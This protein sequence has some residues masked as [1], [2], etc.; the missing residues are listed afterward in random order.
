MLGAIKGG[1]MLP[2]EYGKKKPQMQPPPV[3]EPLPA[4]EPETAAVNSAAPAQSIL[5]RARRNV[6]RPTA[7]AGLER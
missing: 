6:R 7:L 1:G 3:E 2:H 5:E 4:I